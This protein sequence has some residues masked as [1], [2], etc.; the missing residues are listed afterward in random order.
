ME[1]DKERTQQIFRLYYDNVNV[2][3]AV[4]LMRGQNISAEVVKS[5]YDQLSANAEKLDRFHYYTTG[6]NNI[7]YWTS[8][9]LLAFSTKA[10]FH[11]IKIIDL[12]NDKSM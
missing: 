1:A 7:S 10:D 8:R 12:F 9:Y 4:E 3:E 5:I 6:V 2:N 11:E